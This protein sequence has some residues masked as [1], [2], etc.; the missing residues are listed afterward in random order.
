[1]RLETKERWEQLYPFLIATLYLD[2]AAG[3][4]FWLMEGMFLLTSLFFLWDVMLQKKNCDTTLLVVLRPMY[5]V[6]GGLGAYILWDVLGL[7]RNA[8]FIH[9]LQKEK[10]VFPMAFILWMG[11][12]YFDRKPKQNGTKLLQAV[13]LAGA[14]SAG[15]GVLQSVL[16]GGYFAPYA[17]RISLR[18][19]YNMFSQVVMMGMAA[20]FC[21]YQK[22]FRKKAWL[23]LLLGPIVILSSS[24]K[25]TVLMLGL[26][27]LEIMAEQLQIPSKERLQKLAKWGVV[28]VSVFVV[29]AVGQKLLDSRAEQRILQGESFPNLGQ[30]GAIERLIPEKSASPSKRKIIWS[31]AAE[32]FADGDT[33]QKFFG[34]GFCYDL[35]LYAESSDQRL[36][37]VY[38]KESL[39]KLSAHSFLLADLVNLG[40]VGAVL[41]GMIWVLLGLKLLDCLKLCPDK[42]LLLL[43]LY[44]SILLTNLLSNRYGF[45]YDKYFW[46]LVLLLMGFRCQ[47]AEKYGT[48]RNRQQ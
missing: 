42:F 10:V 4:S 5:A 1:M 17:R 8:D 6:I 14:V 44:G 16:W 13:F 36:T 30:S 26:F 27:F 28:I 24:R 15:L 38:S 22:D 47:K 35:K 12:F 19:D 29:S 31:I 33:V 39:Q 32:E 37:S 23:A 25:N 48:I 46:L 7:F 20:G 43:F 41:G 34:K 3:G 11:I 18:V 45:L 21:L 40:V 9:F 2:L